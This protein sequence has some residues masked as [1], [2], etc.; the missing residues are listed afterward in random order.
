[1]RDVNFLDALQGGCCA[2][3]ERQ[4]HDIERPQQHRLHVPLAQTSAVAHQER[5]AATR[6]REDVHDSTVV[7]VAVVV[8]HDALCF[9]EHTFSSFS[10]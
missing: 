1:M 6:Q 8:Q 10:M 5:D 9:F 7:I 4:F 2:I 3:V